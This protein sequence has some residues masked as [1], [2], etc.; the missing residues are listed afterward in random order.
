MKISYLVATAAVF[1]IACGAPSD[2]GEDARTSSASSAIVGGSSD[3]ADLQ[4][5]IVYFNDTHNVCTGTLIAPNVVLTAAHCFF[6]PDNTLHTSVTFYTGEGFPTA[7]SSSP[8]PP[9][10]F[11]ASYAAVAVKT[12]PQFVDG[13]PRIAGAPSNDV[14][15]IYLGHTFRLGSLPYA[16]T[17]SDE[18]ALNAQ[19][20][21]VGFG[22]HDDGTIEEKYTATGIIASTSQ[23]GFLEVSR[24]SQA[25][26]GIAS[27]GDSGGP[28]L[29]NGKIA[30]ITKCQ[31]TSDDYSHQEWYTRL[32][33]T[34][35]QNFITSTVSGWE[36]Q[37]EAGCQLGTCGCFC[38]AAYY[39]C[40][41]GCGVHEPIISCRP[42]SGL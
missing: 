30:A 6:E 9:L 29:Y 2:G 32:D 12:H 20:T 4:V 26:N 37:C 19:V 11:T 1:G 41:R 10:T 39:G 14:G 42:G 23:S 3:A 36:A 17:S 28:L 25:N 8:P 5:G 24:G 38:L 7:D 16:T 21:A 13:C 34:S 15:L 22:L 18:P 27:K 33:T 40:M 35:V 31:S